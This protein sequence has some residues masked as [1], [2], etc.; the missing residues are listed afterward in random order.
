MLPAG[1]LGDE[2]V[3]RL[4]ITVDEPTRVGGIQ[5]GSDLAHQ[6]ERPLRIERRL[7]LEQG[8]EIGALDVAH[9]DVE[10]SVR[11]TRV[12]HGHDVRVV[13]ARGQLGLDEE[14]L[15]EAHVLSALGRDEL[16]RD[17]PP[18]P[19]V[20]RPIDDAHAAAPEDRFDLVAGK[21]IARL[22][23]TASDGRCQSVSVGRRVREGNLLG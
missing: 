10:P 20:E 21:L 15:A 17:G 4:H 2:D 11:L 23:F 8:A 13:E 14:A 6:G 7:S 16:Q 12:V 18:Q 9:G 3:R 19:R 22:K 1:L 5:R